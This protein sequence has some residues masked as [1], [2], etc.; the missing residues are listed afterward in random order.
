VIAVV[1]TDAP[2]TPHQCQALA[3]RVPLGLAR[4]GTTGGHFS[5]DIFLAFSTGNPGALDSGFPDTLAADAE[6]RSLQLV[7]WNH[8][9]VLYAATVQCVEEAVLNALVCNSDMTGR[10]GHLSYALPHDLVRERLGLSG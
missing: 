4:T 6:L 8:L 3:R 2:L 1:A 7:P 5:G 9:D 10:S